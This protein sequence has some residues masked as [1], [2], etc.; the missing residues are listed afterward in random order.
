[1]APPITR[2]DNAPS[3]RLF[4]G[5]AASLLPEWLRSRNSGLKRAFAAGGPIGFISIS[6][7]VGAP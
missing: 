6:S 3:D 2:E 7:R 4:E 5:N 1:M